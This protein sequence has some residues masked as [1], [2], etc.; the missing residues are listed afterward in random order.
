VSHATEQVAS[1]VKVNVSLTLHYSQRKVSAGDT[2]F[3][4]LYA[5]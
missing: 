4:N 5:V 1:G 3:N 2:P